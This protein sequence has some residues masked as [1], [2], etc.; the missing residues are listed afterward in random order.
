MNWYLEHGKE[1]D[2]VISSNIKIARN[3]QGYPFSNKC[4]NSQ[5]QEILAKIEEILPNMGYELQLLKMKDM[6]EITKRSLIEKN[7]ITI[8][9]A[10]NPN[11]NKAIL[12]NKEENIC[13]M[14]N[15]EDHIE[16]QVFSEG[17]AINNLLNLAI[18]IDKKIEEKLNYAYSKKYGFLTACPT[19]VGT[20]M[21][22]S[23]LVHVPALKSTGNI[24]KILRIIN[25]F[26]MGVTG[27][28]GDGS[29]EKGDIYRIFNNQ[30]LGITE[31]EI[32]KNLMTIIEKVISGEREARTYLGKSNLEFENN[33]YR[34]FGLLK[35][36]KLITFDECMDLLSSIKLGTDMGIIKELDDL[37]IK[38]LYLYTKPANLQ[39]YFGQTMNAK[40]QNIKRCEII[41]KIMENQ[42]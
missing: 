30:T 4:S 28:N 32:A 13:L 19:N 12:I 41:S 21:H 40:E 36:S 35:Y 2:I 29:K 14:I 16:L 26:G 38:K 10:E 8:E 20:G 23:A 17:L 33:I 42:I 24:N 31:E 27:E 1:S 15:G 6:D 34:S 22:V 7:I 25:N 9:F 18:E 37:K 11:T 5:R 3:I 39:K